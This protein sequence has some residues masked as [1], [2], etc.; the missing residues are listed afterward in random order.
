MSANLSSVA[1]AMEESTTNINVVATATEEMSATVNEI[2]QNAEKARSVVDQ[3][4]QKAGTDLWPD[5]HLE[6]G[7]HGHRQGGGNDYWKS[8]S[9]STFWPLNATIEAARAGEAG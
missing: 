3:A 6:S 4:I 2:A 8:P 9:R 1:A 5:G 7:R